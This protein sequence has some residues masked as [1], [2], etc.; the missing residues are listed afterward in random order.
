MYMDSDELEADL[1]NRLAAKDMASVETPAGEG[2]VNVV[3]FVSCSG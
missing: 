3:D 2:P 1:E